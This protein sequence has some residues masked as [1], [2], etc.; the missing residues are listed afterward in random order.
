M[1]G[2][3]P[4]PPGSKQSLTSWERRHRS[5]AHRRFAALGLGYDA[6]CHYFDRIV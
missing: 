4:E 6:G 2:S 1:T 5:L 3:G